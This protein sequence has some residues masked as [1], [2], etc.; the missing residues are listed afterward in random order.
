MENRKHIIHDETVYEDKYN[1]VTKK[2]MKGRYYEHK[3]IKYKAKY[4][5]LKDNENMIQYGGKNDRPVIIL[6]NG[7]GSSKVWWEYKYVGTAKLEKLD[8]LSKLKKLGDVHTFNLNHFNINYYVYD[9]SKKRRD[10]YN[11]LYMKYKIHGPNL[12][13]NLEDLDYKKICNNVYDDVQKKYGKDRKMI[14]IGHSYGGQLVMLFSNIFKK[15]CIFSVLIDNPPNVIEFYKKHDDH[16]F[17]KMV[18]RYFSNND[19]LH[20]ILENIKKSIEK[21]K[22]VHDFNKDIDKVRNMIGYKSCQDRIKYFTYKLSMPTFIFRAYRSEPKNKF[23]RE[24]NKY[25]EFEKI[26]LEENNKS[27]MIKYFLMLD[28]DHYIWNKKEYSDMIIDE[29]SCM[30]KK[31]TIN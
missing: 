5:E 31:V 8:F 9:D 10:K 1:T 29:I 11:K 6:F 7:F 17:K 25:A 16:K 15:E 20:K 23:E 13:F 22:V 18:D 27:A 3:Y 28:A 2:M 26:T 30:L 4:L 24:W 19:D 12:N 14:P 21:N